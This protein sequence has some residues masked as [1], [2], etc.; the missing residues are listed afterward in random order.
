MA[1]SL[2]V[3]YGDELDQTRDAL[4]KKAARPGVWWAQGFD[5]GT[6]TRDICFDYKS[7]EELEQSALRI[8]QLPGVT[9]GQR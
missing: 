9:I 2:K 8:L 1:L 7:R 6:S 4:I 3:E 5:F